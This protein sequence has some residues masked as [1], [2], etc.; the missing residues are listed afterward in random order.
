M[1]PP[2]DAE[3]ARDVAAEEHYRAAAQARAE[4]PGGGSGLRDREEVALPRLPREHLQKVHPLDAVEVLLQREAH[5]RG[6][7][8]AA[9]AGD[10]ADKS[11]GGLPDDDDLR[12]FHT[13]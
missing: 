13:G 6:E 9:A 11:G 2:A 1:L 3:G 8:R 7:P 12:G 10:G 4:D 5:H